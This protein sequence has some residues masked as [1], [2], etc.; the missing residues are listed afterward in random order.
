MS[1]IFADAFYFIALLNPSDQF[2]GAAVQA[3]NAINNKIITTLWVLMEVADAL[4]APA[5]RQRTHQFLNHVGA[6]P[7]TTVIRDVDPWYSRGVQLFGRRAD[8]NWSLTDCIS[9]EVMSDRGVTDALTGDHHFTQAGF[10]ALLL[11]K[12]NP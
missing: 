3:T 9:F 10:Q 8:K 11:Q 5:V 6:D 12:A 1:E 4:S 7:N 2:H